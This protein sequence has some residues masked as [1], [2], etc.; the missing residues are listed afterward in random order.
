M[1]GTAEDAATKLTLHGLSKKI[2]GVS[3]SAI[4]HVQV[5]GAQLAV[6]NKTVNVTV[7]ES[8]ANGK[9]SVNGVDVAVHGLGSAA[10]TNSGAYDASGSAATVKSDV[11]GTS[12]DD[13]T[14]NTIYGVKAYADAAVAAKDVSATGDTYVQATAGNNK[15]TVAATKKLIGAVGKA[16]SALQSVTGTTHQIAV[17]E[18]AD[19]SQT[20]SF[21]ADAV[22]DCGSF[23]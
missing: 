15:V 17:T 20:I 18:K 3:S 13:K 1:T 9:I 11:I 2:D 4:E 16:E 10:Y 6:T 23:N 7:T 21:A 14:A 22:F 8:T 19:G 5:N 12:G